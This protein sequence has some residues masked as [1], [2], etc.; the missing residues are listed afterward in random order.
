MENV[1][2]SPVLFDCTPYTV[3]C[4][5]L[6]QH[7]IDNLLPDAKLGTSK[8]RSN[9][10][11]FLLLYPTQHT[12]QPPIQVASNPRSQPLT[13]FFPDHVQGGMKTP[14]GSNP[15]WGRRITTRQTRVRGD[16]YPNWGCPARAGWSHPGWSK[17]EW[18][19]ARAK[20]SR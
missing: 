4:Q 5:H 18:S 7:L 2:R 14:G 12:A 6:I 9:A 8:N 3:R 13:L 16:H 10:F 20:I 1:I 15:D 17:T 11:H 19:S